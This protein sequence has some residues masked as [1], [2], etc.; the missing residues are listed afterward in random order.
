MRHDEPHACAFWTVTLSCGHLTEVAVLNPGWKPADGPERVSAGRLREMTKELQEYRAQQPDA[1]D[2]RK[3]EHMH[4]MLADGWPTPSLGATPVPGN[5][6]SSRASASAG[7]S[8]ARPNK[9]PRNH[10]H[11]P[12]SSNGCGRPKPKP[13]SCAAS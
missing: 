13:T 2:P 9:S 12:A 6:S 11:G 5:R 1:Q 4:R 7:L 3:R 8:R 10:P